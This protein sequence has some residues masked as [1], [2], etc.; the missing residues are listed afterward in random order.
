MSTATLPEL[1]V[2]RELDRLGIDYE[3]QSEFFGGRMQKG[4][5]VADFYIPSRGIVIS[6]IGIY[7]HTDP[8]RRAQDAIQRLS[9]I[10]QG[11]TTI[12]ITDEQIKRNVRHYVE[13]ALMGNDL[14]GWGNLL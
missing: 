14:S 9:L 1:A 4:G 13:E 11:I 7:W 6:V 12:Y 2:Q 8:T 10:A 3:F 5:A